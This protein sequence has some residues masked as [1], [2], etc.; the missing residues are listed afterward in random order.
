[1]RS[2]DRNPRRRCYEA[3]EYHCYCLGLTVIPWA[4]QGPPP[5]GEED[6]D[7]K[8]VMKRSYALKEDRR[9]AILADVKT[10][11]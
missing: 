10:A 6:G 4:N 5:G 11:W 3:A 9:Y 1:M 7:Y 8:G 2:M